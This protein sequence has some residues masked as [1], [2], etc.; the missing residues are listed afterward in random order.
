MNL[1]SATEPVAILAA[2]QSP[3]VKAVAR[4]MASAGIERPTEKFKLFD[5]DQ[6]LAAS[7]LTI[8]ERL[9]CKCALDRAGLIA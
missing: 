4:L 7:K 3:E 6:K 1:H 9:Q 5:L 8:A 2:L